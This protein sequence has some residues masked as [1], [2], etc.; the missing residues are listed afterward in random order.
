[1]KSL[2]YCSGVKEK[3]SERCFMLLCEVALGEVKEIGVQRKNVNEDEDED[4]DAEEE[5]E[6]EEEDG[7][8]LDLKKF[9]SRKG[10]GRRI[11]NPKHT[12]TL[13]S[14]SFLS[15]KIDF[16]IKIFSYFRCTST[17]GRIS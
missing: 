12:I 8:P 2:G 11:P 13:N 17:S 1:M 3:E 14:G 16:F 5:E 6:E 9:Q 4:E 15:I 7:K 10:A